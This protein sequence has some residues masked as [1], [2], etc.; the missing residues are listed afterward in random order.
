MSLEKL[1]QAAFKRDL[2]VAQEQACRFF[3]EHQC[4]MGLN[5]QR[6][7]DIFDDGKIQSWQ[8]LKK[9]V[10]NFLESQV[11]REARGVVRGWEKVGPDL[12]TCLDNLLQ[13]GLPAAQDCLT[14]VARRLEKEKFKSV[15]GK[16]KYYLMSPPTPKDLF[17]NRRQ[18]LHL[19]LART[20]FA[21]LYRLHR[22]WEELREEA[23]AGK[24]Y[25]RCPEAAE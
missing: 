23:S 19:Y 20:F 1:A 22:G 21:A 13:E 5:L 4:L 7:K 24:L 8:D 6:L 25:C 17:D 12:Q 14:K 11:K 2:E 10:G 15:A 18:E 3:L 16:M 9:E